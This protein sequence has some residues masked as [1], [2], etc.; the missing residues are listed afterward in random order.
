MYTE[1][2]KNIWFTYRN[3]LYTYRIVVQNLL[4][5]AGSARTPEEMMQTFSRRAA[6][7][8]F[9]LTTKQLLCFPLHTVDLGGSWSQFS[10]KIIITNPL[11]DID[12][13]FGEKPPLCLGCFFSVSRFTQDFE[14]AG[15]Y[16][17]M[18][19]PLIK[20]QVSAKKQSSIPKWMMW[21][22]C[23]M[24]GIP[25]AVKGQ[26]TWGISGKAACYGVWG[27]RGQEGTAVTS[28]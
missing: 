17:R 5:D 23:A 26:F 27:P 18:G 22:V 6:R 19:R 9:H 15:W 3:I 14:V 4:N 10:S 16:P 24:T 28:R 13:G 8:L 25:E 12:C 7:G 2:N 21:K 20:W 1:R 11:T